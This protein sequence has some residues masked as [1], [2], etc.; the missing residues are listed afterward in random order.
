MLLL[1]PHGKLSTQNKDY[2]QNNTLQIHL[3]VSYINYANVQN[4]HKQTANGLKVQVIQKFFLSSEDTGSR[5]LT[6]SSVHQR[7]C[8]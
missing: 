1:I 7:Q 8:V 6:T 4:C 2:V 3:Y 5:S